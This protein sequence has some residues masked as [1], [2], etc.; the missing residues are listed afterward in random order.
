M[1]KLQW[2]QSGEKKYESGADQGVLFPIGDDGAY[3]AG[4]AWSGLRVV[5]ESPDGAEETA[6]WAD[7][8]K[9][10]SLLSTENFKGSIGAYTSPK[11][12]DA[13]DGTADL[14]GSDLGVTVGQQE[15][16]PFGFSY[17]TLIGSDTVSLGADY[18]IHLVY[19][20]KVSPSSREHNSVNDTPAAVELSWDFTTTPIP[21]PGLKPSA[22]LVIDSTKTDK[23]AL[24]KIEA[25]IYG[26]DGTTSTT[27]KLPTPQEIIDI[28]KPT[29]EGGGQ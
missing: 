29:V 25:L 7:N 24:A 12:F 5:S 1:S 23:D 16:R 15:R 20:A 26:A 11:E 18:K 9:Y 2:D 3:K 22:H 10:A 28:I 21:V 27:S 6:L 4:I 14:G 17:R 19:G 13:M 8:I